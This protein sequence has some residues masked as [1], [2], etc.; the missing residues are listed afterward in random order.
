M[1]LE[2]IYNLEDVYKKVASKHGVMRQ[3][4]I[5]IGGLE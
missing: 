3:Y 5:D 1:I 2:L 4:H